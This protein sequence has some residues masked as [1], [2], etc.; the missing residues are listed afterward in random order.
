M[1]FS[2][3][4]LES[5]AKVGIMNYYAAIDYVDRYENGCT[6][7]C[8]PWECPLASCVPV[9]RVLLGVTGAANAEMIAARVSDVVSKG[10]GGIMVWYAG[11]LDG[12]TQKPALQYRG[13]DAS[14]NGQLTAWADG[15]KA[16][17]KRAP[18]TQLQASRAS[19]S[20]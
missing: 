11:L 2:V 10:L 8:S 6:K 14:Y 18:R 5:V 12:A 1:G 17:Q 7:Y 19:L 13:E 15:L 3:R 4:A 20:P 9:S 16:M